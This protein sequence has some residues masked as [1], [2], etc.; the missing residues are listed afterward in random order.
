MLPAQVTFFH[1]LYFPPCIQIPLHLYLVIIYLLPPKVTFSHT[2][3]SFLLPSTFSSS[4]LHS[5]PFAFYYGDYLTIENINTHYYH[6]LLSHIYFSFFIQ[7]HLH[8]FLV[9]DYWR[10]RTHL[11]P[12]KSI[13]SQTFFL[14]FISLCIYY[15]CLSD[16]EG[17]YTDITT[18]FCS[19]TLFFL[20]LPPSAFIFG[21]LT[22]KN[23]HFAFSHTLLA[24]TS[25]SIHHW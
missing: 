20:H 4:F 7:L 6:N 17:T 19:L 21:N 3:L 5:P 1:I 12:L 13:I 24:F 10:T 18:L 9:I 8:S 15:L 25:L 2:L 16:S 22:T 14:A 11:L 23:T